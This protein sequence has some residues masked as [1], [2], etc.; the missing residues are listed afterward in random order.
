MKANW[1]GLI[2]FKSFF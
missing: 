2:S 1:K